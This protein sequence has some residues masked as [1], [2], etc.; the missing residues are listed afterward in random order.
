MEKIY[1]RKRIHIPKLYR[2]A[3]PNKR[4]DKTRQILIKIIAILVISIIFMCI[5]INA[6]NPII[7]KLCVNASKE[8]A[9]LISNKKA[10][11]IMSNY[12]Y[13]DMVTIYRDKDDNITMIKSNIIAVNEI[14]SDVAIKIQE[15]FEKNRDS[16]INVK[17]RKF[18]RSQI[19]IR[20]WT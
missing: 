19:F 17:L 1:S 2:N 11:E 18:N 3:F 20:I 12:S 15:E 14:T 13:E 7:D 4:I 16:R 6:I 10:T 9:T 8:K 5:I